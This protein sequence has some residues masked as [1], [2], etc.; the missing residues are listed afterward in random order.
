MLFRSLLFHM[1]EYFGDA[2]ARAKAERVLAAAAP[3][4]TKMPVMLGHLLGAADLGVHGGVEV[5]IAGDPGRQETRAL[6][7]AVSG[8]YVPSLVLACGRGDAVR[9][10]P[11]FQ[12]RGGEPAPTAY[13]CRRY[14][15]GLPVTDPEALR[16]EI[17]RTV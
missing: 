3:L 5:A 15:C 16:T 13:V 2:D 6:V 7:Q 1:H 12:G 8:V 17:G 11:L 9:G 14:V 4:I 10:L